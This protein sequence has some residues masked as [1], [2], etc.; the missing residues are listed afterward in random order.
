MSGLNWPPARSGCIIYAVK[1]YFGAVNVSDVGEAGQQRLVVKRD[2]F[3]I[4]NEWNSNLFANDIAMIKLPMSLI[5]DDYIKAVQL[6][7]PRLQYEFSEA[8]ISGWG[9][10]NG[11]WD[12]SL[13][14]HNAPILPDRDCERIFKS[15]ITSAVPS[16]LICIA[17]DEHSPCKGDSGGP[18]VI[19]H[20]SNFVLLGI[21]SFITNP[22]CQPDYPLTC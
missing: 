21:A 1:I 22:V 2:H 12:P 13:K 20:E 5:F 19:W 18:L 17:T 6:P 7:K 16:S 3:I 15:I 4:H 11:N 14:Y 8:T 10:L 9:H